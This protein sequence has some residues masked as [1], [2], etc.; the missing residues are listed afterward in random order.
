[1]RITRKPL[2]RAAAI[3]CSAVASAAGF[4]STAQAAGSGT[5]SGLVQVPFTCD[6][7]DGS[8]STT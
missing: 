6:S 7:L 4:V 8:W 1:M 3:A 2:A 5:G